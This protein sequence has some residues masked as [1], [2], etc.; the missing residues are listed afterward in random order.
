MQIMYRY[1]LVLNVGFVD[2]GKAVNVICLLV[3]H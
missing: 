3:S 1:N 2:A